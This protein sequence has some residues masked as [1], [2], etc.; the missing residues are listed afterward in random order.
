M[1]PLPSSA[2]LF[3][4]AQFDIVAIAASAGGIKALA[5]LLPQLPADFAAAIIIILHLDPRTASLLPQ[6]LNPM[7]AL[8]VKDAQ[9]GEAMQAGTIYTAPPD[10][11]LLVERDRTLCLTH[12]A[13]VN[14][15]RPAA[16]C[17]L[18]S[19]AERFGPRAIAVIL[20]G[21]GHDG[22]VG[23]EAIKHHGGR[24]IVQDPATADVDSM[25]QSALD[26]HQVDWVLPLETIPSTLV[27]LVQ[28]ARM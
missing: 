16:D 5:Q 28:Q 17:T 20:T 8:T 23:I 6:V 9:T 18:A 26:T 12:S 27:N 25:P 22:A 1:N 15:S 11:H 14:F 3:P 21:Y 24:V 2:V 19:V 13:K 4:A 7:T 10:H